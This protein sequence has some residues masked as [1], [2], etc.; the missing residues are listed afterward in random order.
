[1]AST[2]G[3]QNNEKSTQNSF[4]QATLTEAINIYKTYCLLHDNKIAKKPIGVAINPKTYRGQLLFIPTPA[5]LPEECFV[6][7]KQIE[8]AIL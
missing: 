1:M 5:L 3:S 2:S 8:K 7:I 4:D 6:P